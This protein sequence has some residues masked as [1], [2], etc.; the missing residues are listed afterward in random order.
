MKYR[1]YMRIVCISLLLFAVASFLSLYAYGRFAQRAQGAPSSALPP[2]ALTT[3]LDQVIEPLLKAHP[4]MSGLFLVS[5]NIDAFALRALSAR[6]AGR[7]LDLQYY[8][9]HDDLTGNLLFNE[10][11]QAADRGVRVR[12]LLDDINNHDAS[13]KISVLSEHPMIEVRMFNPARS[14]GNSLERAVDLLLQGFRLNRRMHNKAWI[15]DGRFALVGGRNIGDEYFDAS[16]RTNFL[17]LDLALIGPAVGE[18]SEIFDSFW[19]SEAV[20]PIEALHRRKNRETY[21]NLRDGFKATTTSA[22]ALPYLDH[23]IKS[24]SVEK[25]LS[26][27]MITHWTDNIH[28]YSDPP[29]KVFGE[30]ESLWLISHLLPFQQ[31]AEKELFLISPYFVPG[32]AGR[33]IL[34]EQVQ[35]GV[36]ISVLTNSLSSTDV[37]AVHSGY[38]RYREALLE[39]GIKLHELISQG[40]HRS[41]LFGSSGASL[42]TKAFFD[43]G[44]KAFIGSFNLDPRSVY[45]NTEMGIMFE[46][47][48]LTEELRNLYL[49]N[50]SSNNSYRLFVKNDQ[51]YWEDTRGEAPILFDRDPETTWWQRLMVRVLSW[52]PIEKQL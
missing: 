37:F 41:S 51:L 45:L 50:I 12:I 17:D 23:V 5:E 49:R 4:G 43:A 25:I 46:H 27:Q 14:R 44:K 8:L 6:H 10:V 29:E 40:A 2:N 35:S 33:A 36:A 13:A 42:H 48:E 9:W 20:I 26:G 22:L 16:Q 34:R 18:A 21:E 31:S 32:E 39:D 47:A 19:N 28:V 15:V 30:K 11:L 3:T 24:P 38:A 52:L 7:S 1:Q